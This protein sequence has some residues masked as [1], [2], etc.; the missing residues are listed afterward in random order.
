MSCND[1]DDDDND[2]STTWSGTTVLTQ[3]YQYTVRWWTQ[4]SV[5]L[6]QSHQVMREGHWTHWIVVEWMLRER[7]KERESERERERDDDEVD[8]GNSR[9]GQ[10]L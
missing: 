7:E 3:H 10:T 9:C 2:V 8:Y 1:D 5:W 6:A 4:E